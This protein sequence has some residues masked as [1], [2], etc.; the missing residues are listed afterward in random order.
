[1]KYLKF[2]LFA[3]LTFVLSTNAEATDSGTGRI[4]GRGKVSIIGHTG[5]DPVYKS[6]D[7]KK[8][9]NYPKQKSKFVRKILQNHFDDSLVEILLNAKVLP[10]KFVS[11]DEFEFVNHQFNQIIDIGNQFEHSQPI[12]IPLPTSNEL[13]APP[14]FLLVLAGFATRCRR[15]S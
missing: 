3:L 15:K 2:I 6:F 12:P 9:I 1:M 8:D 7:G 11:I 14:A 5:Q 4:Q 10:D 13:P